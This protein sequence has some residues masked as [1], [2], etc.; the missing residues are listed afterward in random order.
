MTENNAEV[1]KYV[2]FSLPNGERWGLAVS[3]IKAHYLLA[4]EHMK[5][6]F[7]ELK[8]FP[9][10]EPIAW[11]KARAKDFT[12]DNFTPMKSDSETSFR[13]MIALSKVEGV[14]DPKREE[15]EQ[16]N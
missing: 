15:H 4:V 2:V 10:F 9:E 12:K 3:L 1:E 11:Y 13:A 5:K 6:K 7:P 8:Q 14:I 16:A